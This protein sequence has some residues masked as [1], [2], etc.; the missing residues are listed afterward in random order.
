MY[1]P[2]KHL[3]ESTPIPTHFGGQW[4]PLSVHASSKSPGC[5]SPASHSSR[6]PQDSSLLQRLGTIVGCWRCIFRVPRHRYN[7]K[8]VYKL[9]RP[10]QRS[11]LTP[12]RSATEQKTPDSKGYEGEAH[13]KRSQAMLQCYNDQ[14]SYYYGRHWNQ[15]CTDRGDSRESF[16]VMGIYR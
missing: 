9:F 4:R 10:F 7:I 6:I 5:N 15:G 11:C 3:T 2:C 14:G 13:A 1:A 16:S 8:K 12:H